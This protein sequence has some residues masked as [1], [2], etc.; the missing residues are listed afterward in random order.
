MDEEDKK[1]L[2]EL[3][4]EIGND[5]GTFKY[6]PNL[7]VT[8]SEQIKWSISSGVT[9]DDHSWSVIFDELHDYN[10]D[11]TKVG[12]APEIYITAEQQERHDKYP[13]L[14]KAWEDYI[15]LFAL[16]K[17]EPPVVE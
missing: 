2:Q 6:D 11:L 17:G 13:A 7:Q 12:G 1:T 16:S 5:P 4:D 10:S 14:Q 15:A 8:A 9:V 3:F